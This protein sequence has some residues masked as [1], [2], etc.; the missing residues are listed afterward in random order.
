MRCEVTGET[1]PNICWNAPRA[2]DAEAGA[3]AR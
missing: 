3:F 2:F 1:I